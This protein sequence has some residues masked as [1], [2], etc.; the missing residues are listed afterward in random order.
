MKDFRL[1]V[2]ADDLG[3]SAQV[4]EAVFDLMDRGLVTSST[5]LANGPNVE[6]ACRRTADFPACSFGVHLNMTE[7]RPLTTVGD[8]SPFL[9]SVGEFA[10]YENRRVPVNGQLAAAI[11]DEFSE[12]ISRLR[13]L[14]VEVSHIDSHHDVHTLPRV[15]PILKRIQKS[16]HIRKVRISRNIFGEA[17][18]PGM[19]LK[20]KKS[21]Y[22]FW[23]R[24]YYRT[25]TAH[26]FG[27][28]QVYH[29]IATT[30]R[31]G[32]G[33]WE[34][35]VHPGSTSFNYADETELLRSPWQS[36]LKMPVRLISY[37]ELG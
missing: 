13:S 3:A 34:V 35:M 11:F 27:E 21:A 20:L 26:R 5:L 10:G 29:E 4:N 23:L 9:N 1:I 22:N 36:A 2:N 19:L 8:L 14:G 37:L 32:S 17:E 12:Q 16:F 25:Q 7:F 15:F 30:G 24:R 33:T 18:R 31:L 6:E 28:F